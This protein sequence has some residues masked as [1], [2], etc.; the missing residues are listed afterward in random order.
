MR[1]PGF[2]SRKARRRLKRW[3]LHATRVL[4]VDRYT[5]AALNDL[6]HK[7]VELFEGR[8]DGV[9]VEL[10]GN[11]GLQQSNT[12]ALEWIYGWTGLLV[13]PEPELAAECRRNRPRSTVICTG[14]GVGWGLAGLRRDDLIGQMTNA[15][16]GADDVSIVPIAPLSELIKAA[17]IGKH[18]DVL[19]LDVEG[20][21][22][23]VLQGLDL[24]RH[25]IQHLLVETARPDA[26][27]A[28]LSPRYDWA[29]QWSY[30]DHLFSF[31]DVPT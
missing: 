4:R 5:W 19:S 3:R 10:G 24:D 6:D 1:R 2:V 11:D 7:L 31:R 17:G 16:P 23:E 25:R 15:A 14:A 9:F 22:L 29:A 27:A 12:L 8:R 13:E 26:V 21:E 30:H 20:F 18:I 28:L